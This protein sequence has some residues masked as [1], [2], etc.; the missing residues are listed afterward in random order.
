[1]TSLKG[2][3][4]EA[5]VAKRDPKIAAILVYG[6]D[7]GLVRERADRIARQVCPD[8][9]DPFNAIALSDADLKAEP[10]R[11]ADEA[12]QLSMMGGERI[13]RL[14]TAGEAAAPAARLL[15]EGLEAGRLKPTGV[16]LIEAGDLGKSSGLRKLFEGSKAAIALPSYADA[17]ADIRALAIEA[18]RAEDLKF[19]GD[20]LDLLVTLLGEDRGV[21]RAEIDKL[22]LFKGPKSLRTGPSTISLED[23]R[24]MLVD[25]VA[26]AAGEAAAAAA[27]G[28]SARLARALHRSAGAGASPVGTVRA[29]QREFARLRLARGHMAEGASAESAMAR[30]RPPVFFMEQRAFAARLQRWS[31]PKIDAALDLLLEAELGAKSTGMPDEAIVE[32]AALKIAALA[33]R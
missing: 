22:I 17:P 12:A 5:F 21:S 9:K 2:K 14:R 11:L 27:D 3:A 6:P 8:L 29:L 24:L 25:T 7:E 26:D 13:V 16:V 32:R 33:A 18:A 28:A 20:A 1:M 30:L 4:I 23:V 15:V 31:L 10:S 19:D